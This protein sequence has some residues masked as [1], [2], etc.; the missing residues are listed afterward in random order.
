MTLGHASSVD[1]ARR[2]SFLNTN[3]RACIYYVSSLSEFFR[4]IQHDEKRKDP[5]V[6]ELA[7]AGYQA[8]K[9]KLLSYLGQEADPATRNGLTSSAPSGF[10]EMSRASSLSSTRRQAV[11]AAYSTRRAEATNALSD[12]RYYHDRREQQPFRYKEAGHGRTSRELDQGP[13]EQ[14]DRFGQRRQSRRQVVRTA[15]AATMA[16]H[17]S[18][19]LLPLLQEDR[20]KEDRAIHDDLASKLSMTEMKNERRATNGTTLTELRDN[21]RR[22][23]PRRKV[24]RAA[25][26]RYRTSWKDRIIDGDISRR[27]RQPLP[28]TPALANKSHDS[29]PGR[30]WGDSSD[31]GESDVYHSENDSRGFVRKFTPL[32]ASGTI[33][34]GDYTGVHDVD[35][36]S[37][38]SEADAQLDGMLERSHTKDTRSRRRSTTSRRAR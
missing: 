25:P 19:L 11:I 4:L 30:G 33:G 1:F 24:S 23:S 8:V 2:I 34:G 12:Y 32:T 16:P 3:G 9:G 21:H 38:V 15:S 27:D 10:E 22:S 35:H 20:H 31:D 36:G 28:G 6:P 18:S 5:A 13:Q 14:E 7:R 17:S 37:G 26:I 29:V